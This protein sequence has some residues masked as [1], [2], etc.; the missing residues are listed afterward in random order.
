M[1]RFLALGPLLILLLVL[2]AAAVPALAGECDEL[3]E[4]EMVFA[5]AHDE[6]IDY[7]TDTRIELEHRIQACE[8]YISR[9][10]DFLSTYPKYCDTQNSIKD[11]T[12][13]RDDVQYIMQDLQSQ[14]GGQTSGGSRY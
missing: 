14:S 8:I 11:M 5:I 6:I 9:I 10:N 7:Q 13:L 12:E 3:L 2:A 1:K 4:W